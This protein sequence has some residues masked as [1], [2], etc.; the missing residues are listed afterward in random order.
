MLFVRPSYSSSEVDAF[1]KS[2]ESPIDIPQLQWMN[3]GKLL[4]VDEIYPAFHPNT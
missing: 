4:Y 3:E 2:A 1:H